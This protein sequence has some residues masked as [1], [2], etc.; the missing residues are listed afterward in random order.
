MAA[1]DDKT[2]RINNDDADKTVR[3]GQNIISANSSDD[4]DKTVRAGSGLISADAQNDNDSTVRADDGVISYDANATNAF[5]AKIAVNVTQQTSFVLNQ[6][7]YQKL[8]VISESTGEAQIFLLEKD[9]EKSVLKLYYPNIKPKEALIKKMRAISHKDILRVL[10]YGYYEG[11]FFELLEFAAGGTLDTYLPIKDMKRI[12]EIVDETTD[13]LEYCHS[14]GIIHRDIKP[15]N[16]F[17]KNADGSDVLIGDFVISSLLDENQE[18]QVTGQARTMVYAAPE[19]YQSLD[20]KAFVSKEL[21]Y[22]ALGIMLIKIWTAENPFK[23]IPEMGIMRIKNLGKINIP[24]DMPAELKNLIKGLTVVSIDKRWGYQ[25]IKKWMRGEAV[26]VFV[27]QD[28]S[29]YKPFVYDSDQDLVANTPIE[30]AKLLQDHPAIGKKYLYRGKIK[31]WLDECNNLKLSVTL[32]EIYETNYPKDEEA[33]LQAAIFMLDPDL[34]YIAVDGTKCRSIEDFVTVLQNNKE[35]YMERLQN[36]NDAFYLYFSAHGLNKEVKQFRKYFKDYVDYIAILHVIYTLN[37]EA[38]FMFDEGDPITTPEELSSRFWDEPERGKE[39]LFSNEVGAWIYYI[40]QGLLEQINSIVNQFEKNQ[41]A[42]LVC[43]AYALDPSVG[44]NA[45]DDSYCTTKEEL[46][47]ALSNNVKKYSKQLKN[48]NDEFYMFL[49]ARGLTNEYNAFRGF[50]S[51]GYNKGKIGYT[52]ADISTYKI[53]RG[54]GGETPFY[55]D[56]KK[57]TKPEQLQKVDNNIKAKLLPELE[58]KDSLLNAWLSVFFHEDPFL[59]F[60]KRGDYENKLKEYVQFVESINPENTFVKRFNTG[61][62]Y[63]HDMITKEGAVDQRFN[64]VKWIFLIFPVLCAGVLMYY[65]YNLESN[66]LPGA[67]WDVSSYYYIV[68][69]IL[70]MGFVLLG[71]IDDGEF[72]FSTLLFGGPIVGLIAGVVVYYLFMLTISLWYLLA[73]ILAVSLYFVFDKILKGS[74]T[75]QNLRN[76]LFD[77]ND[78]SGYVYEPLQ[79]AFNDEPKFES[80]KDELLK[81][82]KKARRSTKFMIFRYS[83]LPSLAF[84]TLLFFLI[85]LD[86]QYKEVLHPEEFRQEQIQ[87]SIKA[88]NEKKAAEEAAKKPTRRT[89]R[90]R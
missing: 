26:S 38:P 51:K 63:F 37:P 17:Y 3:T 1:D 21:D 65:V 43:A 66:P 39:V 46:A 6:K 10:D 73:G 83:A 27:E 9:G 47:E 40:D 15:E 49:I 41:D 62:K 34:P 70:T 30:M 72:S 89:R 87:D 31:N 50:Y 13:A 22:Y 7:T 75:D 86:P 25:E 60:K 2:V 80:S 11:R 85:Y 84:A 61:V 59:V 52:S 76:Q 67:F 58:K 64:L 57:F 78:F 74:Y 82:Y 53:I 33:G 18:A 36:R 14:K 35:E 4:P 42:G 45:I 90:T 71:M 55:F 68:M 69:I 24:D 56:G 23:G 32:E 28:Q 88:A 54:F 77:P 48:G 81:T 20:G 29:K 5:G 16:I 8:K 79:F 12:K 44:Y 19:L